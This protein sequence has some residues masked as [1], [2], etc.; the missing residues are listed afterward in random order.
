MAICSVLAVLIDN[1]DGTPKSSSYICNKTW[2]RNQK[3]ISAI[4]TLKG[5]QFIE[6]S[7]NGIKIDLDTPYLIKKY[8]REKCGWPESAIR[9]RFESIYDYD[10]P[11]YLGN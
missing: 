2:E 9:A 8:L 1:H 10:R 3:V 6:N 5:K 4:Q 11:I 7:N